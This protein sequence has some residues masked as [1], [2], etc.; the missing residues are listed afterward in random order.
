MIK[1]NINRGFTLVELLVV[2]SIIG[3][4]STVVLAA[5]GGAR[6]KANEAKK[7]MEVHSVDTALKMYAMDV[8]SAPGNYNKDGVYD[9]SGGGNLPAQEGTQAYTRSMQQ[10]VDAGVLPTIP[11]SPSGNSYYY[12]NYGGSDG[13]GATFYASS[14]GGTCGSYTV[15]GGD[16]L[17]YG[18]V[19]G[20][21]G[22][23]WLDRNLGATQKATAVNDSASYGDLYQWG[24]LRDGHQLRTSGTTNTQSVGDNPGNALFI[25]GNAGDWR[26]TPNDNL[27]QGVNGI[28]NPCPTGFRLPTQTEWTALVSAAGITNTATAFSS[29]LHLPLAGQRNPGVGALRYQGSDGYYWSSSPGSSLFAYIFFFYSGVTNPAGSFN[30]SYGASVRCLKD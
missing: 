27:W 29:S 7:I 2:I 14:G 28:N 19:L 15:T 24:R 11:A 16:G 20:A 4:L 23:C 6:D 25:E 1:I 18:T 26:A 8:G 17:T 3:T 10:L 22:K 9:S 5:L 21:D 12:Y 30:R 13:S